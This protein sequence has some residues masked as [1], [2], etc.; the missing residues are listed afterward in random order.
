[1]LRDIVKPVLSHPT[2][3]TNGMLFPEAGLRVYSLVWFPS[4]L[5]GSCPSWSAPPSS[6][7]GSSWKDSEE[8]PEP[9]SCNHV[10][11]LRQP[12]S[13]LSVRGLLSSPQFQL[14]HKPNTI[15]SY[16][17]LGQI[18]LKRMFEDWRVQV[19]CKIAIIRKQFFSQQS[20]SQINAW[21][22]C[23]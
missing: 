20:F 1:M 11:F 8:T 3:I 7:P 19:T 9:Q 5:T 12:G 22:K 15:S 14:R 16:N 17:R 6:S 21:S 10:P 18:F 4:S 23:K 13:D 2:S